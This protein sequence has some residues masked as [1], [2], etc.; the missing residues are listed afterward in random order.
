MLHL[1]HTLPLYYVHSVCIFPINKLSLSLSHYTTN[2]LQQKNLKTLSERKTIPHDQKS[3]F[4]LIYSILLI[5]QLLLN[6][7]RGGVCGLRLGNAAG[8]L[9]M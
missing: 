2:N 3:R 6:F 5:L 7:V 9:M 1:Y 4:P 8:W